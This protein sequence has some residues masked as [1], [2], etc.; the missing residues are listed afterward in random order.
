VGFSLGVEIHNAQ[1]DEKLSN[2]DKSAGTDKNALLLFI[3]L[4]TSN[5]WVYEYCV[6][7][8]LSVFGT[9][10]LFHVIICINNS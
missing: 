5:N 7:I 4:R 1:E 3:S 2:F 10:R 8:V 9:M 6:Q